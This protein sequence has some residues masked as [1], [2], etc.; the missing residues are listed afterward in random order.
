MKQYLPY[1][2]VML[3][4]FLMLFIVASGSKTY[5]L[6]F[7]QLEARGFSMSFISICALL[8]TIAVFV[9]GMVL[10]K[11]TGRLGI[12]RTML[13]GGILMAAAYLLIAFS[14]GAYALVIAVLLMGV[15]TTFSGYT[16]VSII[17]RKWFTASYGITV[18]IVFT[19]MTFGTSFYSLLYGKLVSKFS[20]SSTLA[21]LAL[22]PIILPIVVDR[23]L[24]IECP[25]T[26]GLKPYNEIG[27][28]RSKKNADRIELLPEQ[29]RKTGLFWYIIVLIFL[30]G[31]AVATAQS[32]IPAYLEHAGLPLERASYVYSVMMLLAA[33]A[34]LLGGYIADRFSVRT[35]LLSTGLAYIFGMILLLIAGNSYV[36]MFVMAVLMGTA[37]PCGS[38]TPSLLMNDSFGTKAYDGL[39]GIVQATSFISIGIM[40]MMAGA[41]YDKLHSYTGVF[42]ALAVTGMVALVAV[43]L[44]PCVK[45]RALQRHFDE[46]VS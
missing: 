9:S 24:V 1:L 19:G 4:L 8:T 26:V 46:T 3:G 27:Q 5:I 34:S 42:I 32:F 10:H 13:L 39:L 17:L 12:R 29:A 45:R 25:E 37:Y 11:V 14:E 28:Q 2:K 16:P 44:Y 40:F 23:F 38:L 6:M 30:L 7:S 31:G 20:F 43:L 36:L 33:P 18:S 35:F 21:I 22:L 41:A 15:S